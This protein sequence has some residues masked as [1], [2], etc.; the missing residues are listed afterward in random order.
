MLHTTLSYST[1]NPSVTMESQIH[2]LLDCGLI[3][4]DSVPTFMFVAVAPPSKN[5]LP[6]GTDLGSSPQNPMNY[7]EIFDFVK[8]QTVNF[9]ITPCIRLVLGSEANGITRGVQSWLKMKSKCSNRN[10]HIV[11]VTI[12][13]ATRSKF[14]GNSENVLES[15]N[16]ANA[17]AILLCELN[18]MK[19]GVVE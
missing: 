17:A 8:N 14:N 18:R 11:Y 7:Y 2:A 19:Q 5:S 6:V 13:L 12:P 9:S 4:Q 15:L 1:E 16:V 3:R 10:M